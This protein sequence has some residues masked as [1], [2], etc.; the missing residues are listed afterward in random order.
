[1]K[2]IE[3]NQIISCMDLA[4]IGSIL[5]QRGY[6]HASKNGVWEF[7]PIAIANA[8]KVENSMR[9]EDF[10]ND[11]VYV[12]D[13]FTDVKK[14]PNVEFIVVTVNKVYR[15]SD[16]IEQSIEMSLYTNASVNKEYELCHSQIEKCAICKK[17]FTMNEL[18]E[19]NGKLICDSCFEKDLQSL[20]LK[21]KSKLTKRRIIKNK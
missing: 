6:R 2:L 4:Q 21:G 1:M 14:Y 5:Q 19:I 8:D 15:E 12:A 10:F 3:L 16:S 20:K 17:E 9:Y 7:D 18:C 11:K 13:I